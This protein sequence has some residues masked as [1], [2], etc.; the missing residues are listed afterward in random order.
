MMID[1]AA[2]FVIGFLSSFGHCIGMC[3]GFV[4]A[5]SM[6]LNQEQQQNRWYVISPHILYL[7][8]IHI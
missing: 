6:R 5:Y 3:G 2:I 1:Y 4:T 7:S 8:L